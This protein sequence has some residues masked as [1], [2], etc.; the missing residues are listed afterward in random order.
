MQ[1]P[2]EIVQSYPIYFPSPSQTPTYRYLSKRHQP[3]HRRRRARRRHHRRSRRSW[4]LV[5]RPGTA[6]ARGRRRGARQAQAQIARD[7]RPQAVDQLALV[8]VHVAREAVRA[9]EGVEGGKVG[10]GVGG[11]GGRRV[12]E[13][14]VGRR[15]DARCGLRADD[16]VD[17]DG[18]GERRRRVAGREGGDVGG[19]V[20][21]EGGGLVGLSVGAVEEKGGGG[22]EAH[23]GGTDAGDGGAGVELLDQPRG[24]DVLRVG[25]WLG[26]GH[27]QEEREEAGGEAHRDGRL[28]MGSMDLQVLARKMQGKSPRA[29]EELRSRRS[30]AA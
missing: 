25:L 2:K 5:P 29:T 24:V 6:R 14:R 19:D 27:G 28:M 26:E 16:G 4:P 18:A 21:G 30:K 11:E 13:E 1:E 23:L 3:R 7:D 10:R 12:G 20:G 8:G 9:D 17:G 15:D 22:R